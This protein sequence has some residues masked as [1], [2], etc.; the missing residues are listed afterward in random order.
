MKTETIPD[1]YLDYLNNLGLGLSDFVGKNVLDI[2][3]GTGVFARE[4]EQESGNNVVIVSI[5]RSPAKDNCRVKKMSTKKLNFKDSTFDLVISH[6]AL[7]NML[8]NNQNLLS[9]I[10]EVLRVLKPGG[11]VVLAPVIWNR[12]YDSKMGVDH[13]PEIFKAVFAKLEW[14]KFQISYTELDEESVR[15]EIKYPEHK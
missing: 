9:E 8:R 6:S 14:M 12:K 3:A 11:K 10:L 4:L 7:P 2:G 15:V 1:V 13:R 5:D